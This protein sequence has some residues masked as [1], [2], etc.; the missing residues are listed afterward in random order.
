MRQMYR[1]GERQDVNLKSATLA[2]AK[3]ILS[4]ISKNRMI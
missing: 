3:K 2:K 1:N 4:D